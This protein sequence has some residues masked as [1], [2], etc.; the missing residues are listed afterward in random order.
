MVFC[1]CFQSLQVNLIKQ[2]V[3]FTY[4]LLEKTALGCTEDALWR[5]ERWPIGTVHNRLLMETSRASC[6]KWGSFGSTV[7]QPT[8]V[9]VLRHRS[10]ASQFPSPQIGVSG[11]LHNQLW[12]FCNACSKGSWWLSLVEQCIWTQFGFKPWGWKELP[13]IIVML[14]DGQAGDPTH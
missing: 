2:L 13:H 10:L 9:C 14:G 1:F 11:A 8:Y 7:A 4:Y 12:W 6:P 3:W 5:H